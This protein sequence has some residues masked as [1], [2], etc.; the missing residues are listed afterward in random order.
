M[1][2]P[3]IFLSGT[4]LLLSSLFGCAER[5]S[6]EE[7]EEIPASL[8]Q[9]SQ[10][11][12]TAET[13]MER[14]DVQLDLDKIGSLRSLKEELPA[15]EALTSPRV[16]QELQTAIDS[17][18]EVFEATGTSLDPIELY[19]LEEPLFIDTLEAPLFQEDGQELIEEFAEE[20]GLSRTD[21]AMIHFYL[22]YLYTLN[23]VGILAEAGG[24]LY[25]IRYSP[26]AD[27]ANVYD[28]VF[29]QNVEGLRP[30]EVLAL[31]NDQQRQAMVNAIRL[32]TGGTV[33]AEEV[34]P[35]LDEALYQR[36]ALFHLNEAA[37]RLGEVAPD[38]KAAID[39]LR[40]SVDRELIEELI[41]QLE[42][43]GF[44]IE[45]LPADLVERILQEQ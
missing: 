8:Q 35:Q 33:R 17:F 32:L 34:L 30:R 2:R 10:A 45:T 39:E 24:E 15:P 40:D 4:L 27:S 37:E 23:A 16:Q 9:A 36:S 7:E 21:E 44:V 14:A 19:T 6:A 20:L 18:Y 25:E 3:L 31:F 1:K 26:E 29:K 11:L 43:W 13:A 41:R 5:P 28:F 42:S 38:L 22:S 12:L